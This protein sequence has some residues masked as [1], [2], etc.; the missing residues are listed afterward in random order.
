MKALSGFFIAVCLLVSS[1]CNP[2]RNKGDLI[3]GST[4]G[5]ALILDEKQVGSVETLFGQELDSPAGSSSGMK[6]I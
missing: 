1:G 6:P 2:E 5:R 3:V 4:G